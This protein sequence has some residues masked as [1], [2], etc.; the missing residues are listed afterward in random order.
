M[1]EAIKK[2]GKRKTSVARIGISPGTGKIEV[3]KKPIKEYFS[4]ELLVIHA[5]HPLEI[6]KETEKYDIWVNVYGGGISS[7]A[8][9]I[10]LAIARAICEL[11]PEKRPTMKQNRLLTRDPRMVERKKYGHKKARKKFQFSKR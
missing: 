9:A 2:T 6:L 10:R 1:Q 7:Q 3:N 8:N 4:N 5:K 11:D